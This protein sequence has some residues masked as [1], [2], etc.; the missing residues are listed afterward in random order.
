[1]AQLYRVLM[2]EDDPD[3]IEI[4]SSTLELA[5]NM[6]FDLTAVSRLDEG[7]EFLSRNDPDF[8]L[9][10]LNLPDSNG[11]DTLRRLRAHSPESLL[12]VIS[13]LMADD[14]LVMDMLRLGAQEYLYKGDITDRNLALVMRHAL[15]RSRQ[16]AA[17]QE[18]EARL[19]QVVEASAD[20][21]MVVDGEGVV[22]FANPAAQALFER[23][24]SEL[25]GQP[26]GLPLVAGDS[27]ADIEVRRRSGRNAFRG[28][29]PGGTG[30]GERTGI[31]GYAT[32]C[33]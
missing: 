3:D 15:E 13:G 26:F 20:G 7:I 9:L 21:M 1:M 17:L 2:I 30:L 31:P 16:R 10:D 22:R 33:Q 28:Y 24:D 11:L 27:G 12:V 32:R 8:V 25:V 14:D 29:A 19:R 23:E 5:T 18:S 4:V 6:S